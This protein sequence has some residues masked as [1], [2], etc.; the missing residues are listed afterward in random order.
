M[1]KLTV[2]LSKLCSCCSLSKPHHKTCSGA[3]QEELFKPCRLS[4]SLLSKPRSSS[5]LRDDGLQSCPRAGRIWRGASTSF[6]RLD[7]F[8]S[9]LIDLAYS[10][11]PPG[12]LLVLDLE[13]IWTNI[14]QSD[15]T[16]IGKWQACFADMINSWIWLV[17]YY[18]IDRSLIF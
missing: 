11:V 12:L 8:V 9:V 2:N 16:Q 3:S 15:W 18:I 7:H 13:G 1:S 10:L 14:W 4:R 6:H 17:P 5:R